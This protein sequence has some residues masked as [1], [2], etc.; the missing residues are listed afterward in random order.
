[1]RNTTQLR[2]PQNSQAGLGHDLQTI[3]AVRRREFVIAITE[4]SEVIV[5]RPCQKCARFIEFFQRHHFGSTTH[6]RQHLGDLR[7]HQWKIF[8]RSAHIG[9][10]RDQPVA[11]RLD[12]RRIG[13]ALNFDVNPGLHA[14][15]ALGVVELREYAM[16]ITCNVKQRM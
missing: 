11:Q 1:M 4:K 16:L 9:Q 3:R 2:F 12:A 13:D 14:R 10:Y 15:A 5:R 8:D 6:V 7:F